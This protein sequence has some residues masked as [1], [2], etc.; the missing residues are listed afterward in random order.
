MP[1]QTRSQEEPTPRSVHQCVLLLQACPKQD[2][3]RLSNKCNVFALSQARLGHLRRPLL[4]L[5]NS[6]FFSHELFKPKTA[7]KVVYQTVHFLYRL[8]FEKLM[9]VTHIIVQN[10]NKPPHM[11]KSGLQQHKDIAAQHT[12]QE[13]NLMSDAAEQ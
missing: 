11:T 2:G 6:L 4:S 13:S 12:T 3:S 7:R 10:D 5:Y 9:A 8:L 1:F